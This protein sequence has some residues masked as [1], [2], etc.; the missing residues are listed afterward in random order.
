MGFRTTQF[1]RL[2]AGTILYKIADANP[3]SANVKLGGALFI[4][5]A[6]DIDVIHLLT[7]AKF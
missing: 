6:L 5:A 1:T 3:A 7:Q 4:G 2:T